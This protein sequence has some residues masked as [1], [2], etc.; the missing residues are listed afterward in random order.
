MS[1]LLIC[2][3]SYICV[4]SPPLSFIFLLGQKYYHCPT[5]EGIILKSGT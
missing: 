3:L 5:N 1:P 2:P 4:D